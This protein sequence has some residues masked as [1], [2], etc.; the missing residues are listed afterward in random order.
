MNKKRL[1]KEKNFVKKYLN[2]E[3]SLTFSFWIV[4]VLG[5]SVLSIPNYII[6]SKGDQ[7]FETMSDTSAL[8]Y[9]IYILFIFVSSIFIFIGLWKSAS[10]YIKMKKV[11]KQS[12]LWGYL[13]YVYIILS[14]I[15]SI[16][17]MVFG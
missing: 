13:S 9:I 16:N 1:S 15:R 17:V 5:L 7:F 3:K 11:K 4:S 14:I 12:A 6:L 2:G 10:N 8:L